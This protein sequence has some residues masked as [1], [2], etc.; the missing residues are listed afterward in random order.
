M[1]T[2]SCTPYLEASADDSLASAFDCG[3]RLRESPNT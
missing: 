1:E 2:H 3:L